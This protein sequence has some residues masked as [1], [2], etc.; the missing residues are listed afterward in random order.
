MPTGDGV[1]GAD[2]PDGGSPFF[3]RVASGVMYAEMPLTRSIRPPL[4]SE[5]ESERVTQFSNR[6]RRGRWLAGRALAKV[7]VK[8]RL[9]LPGI[10]EIREGAD[11]EPLVYSGGFP[12]SDVWLGITVRHD[13]VSCV[14]ADRPVSLEVRKVSTA[15]A[16]LVDGFVA[17]GEQRALRRLL[18]SATAARSAAWAIKEAAQRATR[19]RAHGGL[20]LR[21]VR[22][23]PTLGVQVGDDADLDVLA[24]RYTDEVAVAIVGRFLLEERRTVRIVL[25]EVPPAEQPAPVPTRS[26]PRLGAAIERSMLRARRIAEARVRWQ[27]RALDA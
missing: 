21:E 6:E 26:M 18:G 19:T 1:D 22:I 24:L 25:D 7:L 15:E 4:L 3:W 23:D 16:E 10:V 14:L 5:W 13:R 12:M 9:G 17:R 2:R 11:G 8:E 27:G 20:E